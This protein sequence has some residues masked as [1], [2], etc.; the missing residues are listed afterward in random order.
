MSDL[1]RIPAAKRESFSNRKPIHLDSRLYDGLGRQRLAVR[2]VP[3]VLTCTTMQD[4]E[5]TSGSDRTL[6]APGD[7]P[8]L[9]AVPGAGA[10]TLSAGTLLAGRYEI[11]QTLGVGGMGAVYKAFDRHLERLVALKT[12]LP[13]LAATS[14]ALTRF[15]Q[16]VLVV[17]QITHKN[18]VR[19]FEISEDKGTKFITM[20][21]IEGSDLKSL[22]LQRGKLPAAEAVTIIRQVCQGLEAAHA[23]GVVHRDLKPQN[24]MVEKNG[25]A[26]V[27]DFGIAHSGESRGVTQTGTFLGTPEYMSPE[28]ALAEDVDARSDIFSLGLIFYEMLTGKVPFHAKTA[29]ET[30]FIRTRKRAIPPVEIDPSVPTAASDIVVRCLEIDR[31]R[32]YQSVSELLTVLETV[33]PTRTIGPVAPARPASKKTS[34]YRN[35]IAVLA[36]LCLALLAGFMLR[37]R[38]F[39]GRLSAVAPMT[40][41]VADFTNTTGDNLFSNTLESMSVTALEGASF[42]NTYERG[43]ARGLLRRL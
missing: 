41:L 17:Q 7:A 43:Q 15:R 5:R 4:S 3:D 39:P 12:I 8:T 9:R 11:L 35:R 40:L 37:N 18:V 6:G 28:Q 13:E 19:I 33:E 29:L 25:H 24:I 30:M 23:A 34:R 38:M 32:R 36:V 1:L 26:L 14:A 22:I 10:Q 20:D 16:E 31:E 42:I 21:F 27:M 2:P